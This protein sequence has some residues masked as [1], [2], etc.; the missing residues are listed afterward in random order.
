MVV[1]MGEDALEVV[2]GLG[3]PLGRPLE[4]TSGV[5]AAHSHHRRPVYARDRRSLDDATRK[6]D[7]WDAFRMLGEWYAAL[8]PY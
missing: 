7:F 2:N 5:A 6:R 1:V 3:V 8:P 4:A